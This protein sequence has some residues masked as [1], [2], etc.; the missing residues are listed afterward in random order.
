MTMEPVTGSGQLA[1]GPD[2]PLVSTAAIFAQA[3]KLAFLAQL[4]N[5]AYRLRSVDSNAS[6]GVNTIEVVGN[7]INNATTTSQQSSFTLADQ[8]LKLLDK[9]DMPGVTPTV[10]GNAAYPANGLEGGIFTRGNAAALVARSADGL[11]ISFRGT[12]DFD[13][14]FDLFSTPDSAQWSTAGKADHYALFADLRVAINAY[15]AQNQT[16]TTI[17]VTGHSLGAGMVDAFMQEHAGDQRYEA[18][19]FGSL[20]YGPGADLNDTRITNVLNDYDIAQSYDDRTD[21]DDNRLFGGYGFFSDPF[22]TTSHEMGLYLAEVEFLRQNGIDLA[23]IRNA[24]DY[25]NFIFYVADSTGQYIVGAGDDTLTGTTA[26]EVIVGGLGNDTLSGA[27]GNDNLVGGVGNDLLDGGTGGDVLNGGTGVDTAT[28][29]S[30]GSLVVVYLGAPSLNYGD[31]V[32]D[33]YVSIEVLVGS[34]YSDYLYSSEAGETVNGGSGVDTIFG[35]GGNDTLNGG[36]DYDYILGGE[37]NDTLN[38]QGGADILVGENGNDIINGGDDFDQIY[39][40]AGT[41]TLN[42]DNGGD[43]IYGGTEADTINGGAGTDYLY[44][45]S[46][47][48]VISGGAQYDLLQG[49]DGNDWLFGGDDPGVVNGAYGQGGSDTLVGGT[50]I[51]YLWGGDGAVDTGNDMFEIHAGGSVDVILDFHAGAGL[52]DVLSLV[53]TGNTSF[54]QMQTAGQFVQVGSYAGVVISAGNVVYLANV[55]IAQLVAD[56]FSFS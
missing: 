29:A 4:A 27:G 13:N 34:G 3:G 1:A 43:A 15:L 48:D 20:G 39:G 47:D 49:N 40:G 51:D 14:I 32:G 56:D 42:G 7:D 37:G 33:S 16:V 35:Y 31:A 8:Y 36:A 55:N 30:A 28:Y 52:G 12:N 6:D 19:T 22:G 10:A 46:G 45:E 41:D 9:Q 18:V 44:G 54:A 53:G 38:G 5:A 26:A 50:G 2:E 23:D 24:P 25:D 11:F 17:Y 21:G